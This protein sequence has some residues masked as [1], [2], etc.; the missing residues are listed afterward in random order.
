MHYFPKRARNQ[1]KWQ[2]HQILS[3]IMIK[4]LSLQKVQRANLQ[5]ICGI[6]KSSSEKNINK[7][8][9]IIQKEA[10]ISQNGKTLPKL[11]DFVKKYDRMA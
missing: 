9:K 3:K 4:G 6:L 5:S 2:K 10:N 8:L 1:P 11:P 7:S